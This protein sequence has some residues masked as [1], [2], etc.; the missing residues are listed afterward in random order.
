M[1]KNN[2]KT[3]EDSNRL[4]RYFT[5]CEQNIPINF[6]EIIEQKLNIDEKISNSLPLE[7]KYLKAL[8]LLSKNNQAEALKIIK[9]V[10]SA[11]PNAPGPKLYFILITLE[12]NIKNETPDGYLRDF[13]V[14]QLKQLE[15]VE[16]Q[17]FLTAL[18]S[19]NLI[20][21]KKKLMALEEC[22]KIEKSNPKFYGTF[23]LLA[24]CFGA[25]GDKVRFEKYSKKAI[26]LCPR[27]SEKFREIFSVSQL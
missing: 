23:V 11:V 10:I 16:A 20:F 26:E 22:H 25:S 15:S 1:V 6:Y 7:K 3:V 17:M 9:E 19:L 13:Y 27:A 14:Y 12:L 5:F 4:H 18:D 24:R 21:N 8:V 2:I